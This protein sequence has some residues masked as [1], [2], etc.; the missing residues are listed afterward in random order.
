MSKEGCYLCATLNAYHD[1]PDL[2]ESNSALHIYLNELDGKWYLM[3]DGLPFLVK[4]CPNCGRKLDE[5]TK[6]KVTDGL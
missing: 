2:Y 6:F 1:G 3:V 5:N 4:H